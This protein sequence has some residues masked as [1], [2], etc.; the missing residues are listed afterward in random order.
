MEVKYTPGTPDGLVGKTFKVEVV[1]LHVVRVPHIDEPIL[2]KV[3][4]KYED[5]KTEWVD[6]MKFHGDALSKKSLVT[7]TY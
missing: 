6:G 4:I 2:K 5:G 1:A 3:K 7:Y